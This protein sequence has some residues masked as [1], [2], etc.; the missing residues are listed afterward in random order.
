M[1]NSTGRM[2]WNSE[3][4]VCAVFAAAAVIV[5]VRVITALCPSLGECCMLHVCPSV[6]LVLMMMMKMIDDDD[7]ET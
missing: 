5:V 1:G 3:C 4:A 6:M 2:F 7:D